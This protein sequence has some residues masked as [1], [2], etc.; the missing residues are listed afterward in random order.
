VLGR[1]EAAGRTRAAVPGTKTVTAPASA[2]TVQAPPKPER[3]SGPAVPQ[4]GGLLAG[5]PLP[6]GNGPLLSA[7]KGGAAAASLP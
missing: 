2:V 7:L 5:S 6:A 3:A 4:L 1:A